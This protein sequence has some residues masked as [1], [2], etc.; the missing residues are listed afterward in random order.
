MIDTSPTDLPV[1]FSIRK[2]KLVLCFKNSNAIILQYELYIE[3]DW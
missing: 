3:I 2:V 1:P